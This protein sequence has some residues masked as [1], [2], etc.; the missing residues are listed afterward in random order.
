MKISVGMF[1]RESCKGGSVYQLSYVGD[2]RCALI[3]TKG[4][5]WA[6]SVMVENK[7][8][9]T[10]REFA[11]LTAGAAFERVELVTPAVFRKPVYEVGQR[12]LQG[13]DEYILARI[14]EET[15]SMVGLATGNRYSKP[16]HT[17]D[18]SNITEAEFNA[19]CGDDSAIFELIEE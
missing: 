6:D 4:Y 10:T 8:N 19:V 7:D 16:V 9:I 1:F 11:A 17:M 14:D 13:R 18:S 12:F 3:S 15:V 2:G 5:L